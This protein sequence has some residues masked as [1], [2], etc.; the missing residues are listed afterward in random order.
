MVKRFG[1]AT[2]FFYLLDYIYNS[3]QFQRQKNLN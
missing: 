3:G 1:K 2:I